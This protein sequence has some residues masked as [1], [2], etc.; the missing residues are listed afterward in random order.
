MIKACRNLS[1]RE[2]F[3]QRWNIT[4][5]ILIQSAGHN[6]AI[7]L[8]KHRV[9]STCRVHCSAKSIW[10]S[11]WDPKPQMFSMSNWALIVAPTL[12]RWYPKIYGSSKFFQVFPSVASHDFKESEFWDP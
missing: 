12:R 8:E 9:T 5:P 2:S 6:R 11:A 10:I 3:L 7:T 4:L 1:V